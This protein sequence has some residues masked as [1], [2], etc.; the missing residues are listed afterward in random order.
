MHLYVRF[1]A[2]ARTLG[3][4]LLLFLTLRSASI[5]AAGGKVTGS[6]VTRHL[7]RI[8]ETQLSVVDWQPVEGAVV[9]LVN[10]LSGTTVATTRSDSHGVF[11][12]QAV[13]SGTYGIEAANTTACTISDAFNVSQ[14]SSTVIRLSFKDNELCS[15]QVRFASP[16]PN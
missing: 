11:S 9:R 2:M 1:T 15:E 5:A 7:Q 13:A 12:F 16:N 14:D 6:V 8:G 4:F 10:V 3:L